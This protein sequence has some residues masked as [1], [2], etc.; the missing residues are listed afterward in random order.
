MTTDVEAVI[1][2]LRAFF[3]PRFTQGLRN[4]TP[5]LKRGKNYEFK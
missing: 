2:A 4:C 3:V 5:R 1:A